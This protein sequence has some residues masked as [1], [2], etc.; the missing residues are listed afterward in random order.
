MEAEKLREKLAEKYAEI[1]LLISIFLVGFS[2]RY[3]AHGPRIGPELDCWFHFRVV[4]Y[5]LSGG[6]PE[7]DPLAY[8]PTGRE[9]YRI[10]FLGLPYFIA[11]SYKIIAPLTGLSLMQYMVAFP[12]VF[13]SLAAIPLYFL[14]REIFDKRTALLTALLWQLIPATM[15]RTH[16]GFVDKESLGSVYIFIFLYL[17]L[18]SIKKVDLKNKKTLF[19]PVLAGIFAALAHWTWGGAMF[20]TIVIALS[21]FLYAAYNKFQVNE[22]LY[23]STII[24]AIFLN[25]TRYLLQP[26]HFQIKAIM[27][28]TDT[29]LLVFS[30]AIF[31]AVILRE[32]AKMKYG[33]EKAKNASY[34][35]LAIVI[36]AGVLTKKLQQTILSLINLAKRSITLERGRLSQTVAENMP[37]EFL[38]GGNN[39]ITRIMNGDWYSHFNIT[40]FIFPVGF[41][42]ALKRFKEKKDFASLFFGIML[43]SSIFAMRSN[44]RLSFVLEPGIA[45]ATAYACFGIFEYV[46]KRKKELTDILRKTRKQKARYH[47]ER[48]LTNLKIINIIFILILFSSVVATANAS[49]SM[50]DPLSIDVPEPWYRAMTWIRENTEENAVI[51]SWW[52]YGYWIQA[53]GLRRTVVDGGNAGKLV[54]NLPITEGLEYRGSTYHRDHDIALMFTSKEDEALKYLRPYVDYTKVPTYV[55]VSYEEFGKSSAI[56]HI[57]QDDLYIFPQSIP[58]TGDNEADSRALQEFIERNGIESYFIVNAGNNFI[59]WITGFAPERGYDPEMKNKL[60]A[61]LLP[62]STGY[63]KGLKHFKLVYSDPWD[64]VLIY[65]IVP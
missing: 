19:L 46:D 24:F 15:T 38:G 59:I 64:Y 49:T 47:A 60:L 13:T 22:A 52:D 57:A 63:G 30:S 61:K 54:Y 7:I 4:K 53:I 65:K 23:I 11:Y 41:I 40:L 32:H 1:A 29:L 18:I 37:P 27:N 39:I 50:L 44:I 17:F 2:V 10:D 5:I 43:I 8:Y 31:I 42:I 14:T 6:I 9:I 34:A 36:I 25:I 58:R 3:L 28:Y 26:E 16:A 33:D 62:F 45:M 56:N 20:F 51:I 35:T 21:A 12:A 55:L 48:E